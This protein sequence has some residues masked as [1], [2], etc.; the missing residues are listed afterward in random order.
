MEENASVPCDTGSPVSVSESEYPGFDFS[1]I[2]APYPAKTGPFAYTH[3]AVKQRGVD[4]R[5]WLKSRPEQLIVVVTHSAF[6]RTS[7]VWRRFANADYR[8]FTFSDDSDSVELIEDELTE[9]GGMGRSEKGIME[10]EEGEFPDSEAVLEG[11]VEER[12]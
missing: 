3:D 6:L 2:E 5:K 1:G 9:S 12:R 4:A 8:V 11:K 10:D 7:V